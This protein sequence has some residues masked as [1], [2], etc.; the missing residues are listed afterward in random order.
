[1]VQNLR[2]VHI[3]LWVAEGHLGL[4][5]LIDVVSSVWVKLNELHQ[6]VDF[7]HELLYSDEGLVGLD[8]LENAT[9]Q[10]GV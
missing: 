6:V 7:V 10:D 1:M 5:E 4:G 2:N 9:N 8:V 3:L